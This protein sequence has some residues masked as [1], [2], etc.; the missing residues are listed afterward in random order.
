MAIPWKHCANEEKLKEMRIFNSQCLA[1]VMSR[2]VWYVGVPGEHKH[3]F[4]EPLFSLFSLIWQ[5]LIENSA[6]TSSK[7]GQSTVPEIL[8]EVILHLYNQIQ[9]SW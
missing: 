3:F 1:E 9:F 8:H 5:D 7:T 6:F 2:A 4:Q